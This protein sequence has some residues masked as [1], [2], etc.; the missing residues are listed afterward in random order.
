M[1][2]KYKIVFDTAEY[3]IDSDLGCGLFKTIAEECKDNVIEIKLDEYHH[4]A[5]KAV[6]LNN[7]TIDMIDSKH[8]DEI[9][10]QIRH[11]YFKFLDPNDM[12][13]SKCKYYHDSF[14][15][16]SNKKFIKKLCDMI[17]PMV[18]HMHI[19]HFT[20]NNE[21]VSDFDYTGFDHE[22]LYKKDVPYYFDYMPQLLILHKITRKIVAKDDC[23]TM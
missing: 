22:L 20:V 5:F 15:Y 12:I 21:K 2:R 1:N 14:G 19:I 6:Y 11:L 4:E 9:E 7:F 10:Q 8:Q 17:R 13:P 3:T 23:K 16:F 18:L